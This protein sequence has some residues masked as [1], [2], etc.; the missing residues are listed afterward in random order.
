MGLLDD[1]GCGVG[2]AGVILGGVADQESVGGG[3]VGVVS[4]GQDA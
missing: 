1:V 4:L 2:E 3:H